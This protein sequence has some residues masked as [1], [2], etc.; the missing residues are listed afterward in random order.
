MSSIR[1][2]PS[3]QLLIVCWMT[4]RPQFTASK[5]VFSRAFAGFDELEWDLLQN[6]QR[7]E[8]VQRWC[9]FKR[10]RKTEKQRF[11]GGVLSS[12]WRCL[13]TYNPCAVQALR[14]RKTCIL[15]ACWRKQ[16]FL[17]FTCIWTHADISEQSCTAHFIPIAL[18]TVHLSQNQCFWASL[19]ELWLMLTILILPS[20]VTIIMS[21]KLGGISPLLCCH[22]QNTGHVPNTQ[23]M[24]YDTSDWENTL[25]KEQ[26]HMR[27]CNTAAVSSRQ[28][29]D[30]IKDKWRLDSQMGFYEKKR[31]FHISIMCSDLSKYQILQ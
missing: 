8:T 7:S 12:Q 4:S 1:S 2:K 3:K 5:A 11:Q 22:T 21:R 13:F 14:W 24:F 26:S 19:F 27:F 16:R 20:R 17:M 28:Q 25:R 10:E 23:K 29:W 6:E 18:S 31:K 9:G 15:G 30:S